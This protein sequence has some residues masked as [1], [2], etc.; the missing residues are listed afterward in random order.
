MN[1]RLKFWFQIHTGNVFQ[2]RSRPDDKLDNMIRIL[3]EFREND[4]LSG[5]LA[6][7][8]A[9]PDVYEILSEKLQ[10]WNVPFIFKTAVFSE[11]EEAGLYAYG[12]ACEFEPMVD[13]Q[14]EPAKPY[15]LNEQE[16]FLFRCPSSPAISGA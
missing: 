9:C 12:K 16:N 2:D 13:V 3:E 15:H 8:G 5:V 11:I 4:Q 10:K 14:L 1:N 6:G 7:W